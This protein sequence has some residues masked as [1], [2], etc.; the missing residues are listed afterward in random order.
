[1]AT[2]SKHSITLKIIFFAL[3]VALVCLSYIF[4]QLLFNQETYPGEILQKDYLQTRQFHYVEV[5]GRVDRLLRS[6][7]EVFFRE[8]GVRFY[9]HDGHNT[10]SNVINPTIASFQ[11]LGDHYYG[12]RLGRFWAPP[13]QLP[14]S[15]YLVAPSGQEYMLAFEDTFIDELQQKWDN[16]RR[17]TFSLIL[18][19]SLSILAAGLLFIR[20]VYLLSDRQE[21]SYLR[22]LDWIPLEFVLAAMVFLVLYMSY[23]FYSSLQ[24]VFYSDLISVVTTFLF[25]FLS[26]SGFLLVILTIISRLKRDRLAETSLIKK[27]FD[28][29]AIAFDTMTSGSK[30][31]TDIVSRRTVLF[32]ILLSILL[33]IAHQLQNTPEVLLIL[34]LISVGLM[35]W[36]IRANKRTLSSIDQ[37]MDRSV[38]EMLK[39]EKTKVELITN[40]SH[41]LKTPLTSIISY[42]DLLKNEPLNEVSQ[43][44]VEVIAHKSSR[45]NQI[46]QDVFDLS[47]ASTGDVTVKRDE[48]DLRRLIEQTVIDMESQIESSGHTL[49]LNLPAYAVMIES[50]GTR[51]YRVLQNIIDN[52][53]KYTHEGTRIFLDLSVNGLTA[54]MVLKNT[55]AYAM[56]FT[57]EN[58]LQRFYRA[59]KA[60]TSEGSG[61]GLSIAESFTEL[62]GG[63]FD[64]EIEGDLFK[65][66]LSFPISNRKG[67]A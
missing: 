32:L 64:I 2:K 61:L 14:S 53:L 23:L 62:S 17:K 11:A 18:G 29:F 31:L 16:V 25:V 36:F 19:I 46:L 13:S 15:A 41:D 43:E 44:Y 34:A 30:R 7:E 51:L 9:Y 8:D 12:Y 52:A 35:S 24:P 63:S 67:F 65:V 3:V 28:A 59:D 66:I 45:L 4:L 38:Q 56:D 27:V 21:D 54:I 26:F 22:Q 47:K 20:L 50:D 39:S 5:R 1:M 57:K 58:V 37:S 49:K 33:F 40:V 48:F 6:G 60:R 10:Y 42:V 55:S